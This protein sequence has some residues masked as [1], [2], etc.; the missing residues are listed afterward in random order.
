[1]NY[2]L[3]SNFCQVNNRVIMTN[4]I[5]IRLFAHSDIHVQ[6]S[7]VTA[8]AIIGQLQLAVRHPENTGQ[9]RM[10]VENFVRDQCKAAGVPFFFK[11]WGEWMPGWP[12]RNGMKKVG[13]KRSG[14]LLDGRKWNEMPEV[15]NAL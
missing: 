7:I 8:V 15:Q 3:H 2:K 10:L 11:Q 6:L 13:K 1:M 4:N 12:T 14:R 5:A 9:S